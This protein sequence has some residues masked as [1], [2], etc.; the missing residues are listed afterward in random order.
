MKKYLSLFVS[1]FSAVVLADDHSGSFDVI[2]LFNDVSSLVGSIGV[3]IGVVFVAC[4]AI[5]LIF[6][7]YRYYKEACYNVEFE[8]E[9]HDA[10][11]N[12]DV[13]WLQENRD[14]IWEHGLD[15]LDDVEDYLAMGEAK[16]ENGSACPHS[17]ECYFWSG[18][19]C[20]IG[21]E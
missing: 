18:T 14:E 21:M 15:T 9:Y 5:Y 20:S 10:L 4:S 2:S 16:C 7:G 13:E 6:L 19:Q 11:R 3:E 17:D 8:G 1:L 12:G